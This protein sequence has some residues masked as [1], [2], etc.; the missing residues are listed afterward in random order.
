M[1]SRFRLD[2]IGRS[3]KALDPHITKDQI[4]YRYMYSKKKKIDR[5]LEMLNISV[6]G[7]SLLSE[8]E[9]TNT[10]PTFKQSDMNFA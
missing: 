2:S 7:S 4:A 6:E 3:M 5:P 8:K 10:V 1:L 9:G